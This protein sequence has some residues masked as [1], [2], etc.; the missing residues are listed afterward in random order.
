VSPRR[1]QST[2][3]LGTILNEAVPPVV[4]R[5]VQL[6][7]DTRQSLAEVASSRSS[8]D[9]VRDAGEPR[10]AQSEAAAT[11]EPAQV[12]ETLDMEPMLWRKSTIPFREDQYQEIGHI[13]A[14]FHFRDD[15]QLT[16][17]EVVR[18]GLDKIIEALKDQE[19]REQILVEIYRQ[20]RS[21]SQGNENI[22]HSKSRGLSDYLAA[23]G[24]LPT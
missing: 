2:K 23:H 18:L 15:V 22:K 13:L 12:Q 1:K 17:A 3:E 5:E 7:V 9:V 10:P 4:A 21:E 19:Q 8:M 16:I 14:E 11:A 6:P 20:Q 24:L